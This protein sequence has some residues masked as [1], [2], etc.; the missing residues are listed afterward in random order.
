MEIDKLKLEG[1][2]IRARATN[3]E[4]DEKGTA[5]FYN[6]H[7]QHISQKNIDELFSSGAYVKMPWPIWQIM[8]IYGVRCFCDQRSI[9]KQKNLGANFFIKV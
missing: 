5:Y 1:M 6:L 4:K 2:K 3:L 8:L 7:K 9:Q